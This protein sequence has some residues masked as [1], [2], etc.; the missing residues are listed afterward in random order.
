MGCKNEVDKFL[1]ENCESTDDEKFDILSWWKNNSTRYR[2][3]SQV[4]RDVLA[5]PISTVAYESAFS[6]EGIYLIHS[7]AHSLLK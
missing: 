3:L 6:T 5:V 7:V 4:A 1:A 2:I